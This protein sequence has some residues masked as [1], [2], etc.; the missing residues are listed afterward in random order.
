MPT[1]SFNLF[2][3]L[4]YSALIVF[5]F[6]FD[7]GLMVEHIS[8]ESQLLLQTFQHAFSLSIFDDHSLHLGIELC[9][10]FPLDLAIERFNEFL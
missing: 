4:I 2:L 1:N 10:Y 3:Q 7:S 6:D 5:F 9:V 8:I